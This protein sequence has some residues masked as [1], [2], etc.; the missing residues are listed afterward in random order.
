MQRSSS[1]SP[2]PINSLTQFGGQDVQDYLNRNQN[3]IKTDISETLQ[4]KSNHSAEQKETLNQFFLKSVLPLFQSTAGLEHE[5]G[6]YQLKQTVQR[7]ILRGAATASLQNVQ[8]VPPL[9]ITETLLMVEW[10][11]IFMQVEDEFGTKKFKNFKPEKTSIYTEKS[12]YE[13]KSWICMC[14][15]AFFL[16]GFQKDFTRVHWVNQ[17]LDSKKHQIM[18]KAQIQCWNNNK[19]LFWSWFYLTF[20]NNINHLKNRVINIIFKYEK[21]HQ[22]EGQDIVSFTAYLDLIDD[23]LRYNDEQ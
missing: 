14:E 19:K 13:L 2:A 20:Q 7:G 1:G 16:K 17:F 15:N 10:N 18:K 6:I 22:W 12:I 9:H 3:N 4:N 21:T 8:N 23:K 11:A 5:K